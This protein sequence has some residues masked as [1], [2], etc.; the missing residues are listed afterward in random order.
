MFSF[1][2]CIYLYHVRKFFFTSQ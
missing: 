1:A 2:N